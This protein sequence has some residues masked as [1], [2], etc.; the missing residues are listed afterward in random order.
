MTGAGVLVVVEVR[1]IT[2]AEKFRAYQAGAREQ[3]GRWG[4]RVVARGSTPMEGTPPF[5]AVMVQEWPSAQAF[6]SWQDS[7]E[8]QPLREIR[9]ACAELRIA[10]VERV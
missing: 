5:G 3:I 4:G 7:E 9:L 6:A 10:V 1:R 2:D 8:Y